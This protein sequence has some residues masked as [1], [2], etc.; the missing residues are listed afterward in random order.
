[1]FS[2]VSDTSAHSVSN[3]CV[4]INQSTTPTLTSFMGKLGFFTNPTSVAVIGASAESGK[5][6]Y[7]VVNNIIKSGY[8]GKIYPINPKGGVIQ[9]HDAYKSILDCPEAP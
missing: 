1:M 3:K 5:V 4:L 8:S 7:T 9:G 6:G 2:G